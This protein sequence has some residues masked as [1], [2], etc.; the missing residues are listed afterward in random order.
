MNPNFNFDA[1]GVFDAASRPYRPRRPRKRVRTNKH[2]AEIAANRDRASIAQLMRAPKLLT[3]AMPRV[4]AKKLQP[5]RDVDDLERVLKFVG[6]GPLLD[7]VGNLVADSNGPIRLG[8]V[9]GLV[10]IDEYPVSSWRTRRQADR[11]H[12]INDGEFWR[13]RR[14]R[15]DVPGEGDRRN[16]PDRRQYPE[17]RSLLPIKPRTLVRGKVFTPKLDKYR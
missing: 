8:H 10:P 3:A 11:R 16:Y 9:M 12:S 7:E 6:R 14:L 5:M 17:R 13:E 4:Q 15:F 2:A 1:E